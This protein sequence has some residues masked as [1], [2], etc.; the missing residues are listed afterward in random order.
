MSEQDVHKALRRAQLN[1]AT[2]HLVG[3]AR[4]GAKHIDTYQPKSDLLS[5][6]LAVDF[7]LTEEEGN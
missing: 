5:A 3:Q 6:A 4:A 1:D 2:R 7:L